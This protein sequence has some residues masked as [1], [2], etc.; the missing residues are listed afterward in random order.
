M[1]SSSTNADIDNGAYHQ[2]LTVCTVAKM[3]PQLF[4]DE[5]HERMEQMQ[6]IIEETD[7]CFIHFLVDGLAVSRLNHF[8]IPGRELIPEQFVTAISASL[9]RYLL[10]KSAT[11]AATS[12][13]LASNQRIASSEASGTGTSALTS[14]NL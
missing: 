7:S 5:R 2:A 6:Q 11:S 12:F 14:P 13:C 8:Q 4:G 1:I 10:N 3:L 9:K